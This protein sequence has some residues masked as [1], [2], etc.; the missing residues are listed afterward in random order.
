MGD[1]DRRDLLRL[2]AVTALAACHG[3]A[4]AKRA[5]GSPGAL[6]ELT[7]AELQKH[8][9]ASLVAAYR[10]RIE[11]MNERGPMLRAVL[12]LDPDADAN[13]AALD[14]ERAAGKSRG[15]LHGIPVLVKDNL[16]TAGKMMTSAGSLALA[17]THAPKDSVVVAKLRAAGA[18]I[19]GKTN[20]SEWANLR[21]APSTSGWSARGGQC[22]NPYALDRSPSGS[23][24]GSAVAVAANLCAVAI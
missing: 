16:D 8:S 10:A 19:L 4:G 17:G 23:S 20:L 3:G 7:I 15:P 1:F 5:S 18:L 14:A 13:A 21:G 11:E 12:E 24:S 9:C 2:G 22:R 6:D